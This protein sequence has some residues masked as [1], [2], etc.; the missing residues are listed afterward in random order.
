MII[1]SG[2][3]QI[4]LPYLMN[5]LSAKPEQFGKL[6]IDWALALQIGGWVIQ[7]IGLGMSVHDAIAHGAEKTGAGAGSLSDS[8]VNGLAASLS[9]ADPQGRS[10]DTWKA[11][12]DTIL[13]PGSVAPPVTACPAGTYRDPTSGAC[14]PAKAGFFDSMS[15]GGWIAIAAVGLVG[16]KA[17]KII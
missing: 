14:M 3:E 5:Q 17:L 7:G 8:D 15:T 6:G 12:L 1:G 9:A 10:V 16:A 13:G 4:K 11:S 2:A